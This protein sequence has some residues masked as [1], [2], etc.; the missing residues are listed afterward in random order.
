MLLHL[1]FFWGLQFTNCHLLY[2][3]QLVY[4]LCSQKLTQQPLYQCRSFSHSRLQTSYPFSFL[5]LPLLYLSHSPPFLFPLLC[6]LLPLQ[7][8]TGF[9]SETLEIF[10]PDLYFFSPFSVNPKLHSGIQ[11]KLFIFQDPRRLC[12]AI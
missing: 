3:H 6:L 10:E 8:R 2:D 5:S 11:P 7:T 1:G 4:L 9:S 12:S